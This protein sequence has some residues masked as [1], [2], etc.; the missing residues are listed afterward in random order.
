MSRLTKR[1][2]QQIIKRTPAELKGTSPGS[3]YIREVLGSFTP[4]EANWSYV[5]G[6]TAD[7]RLVVIRHGEIM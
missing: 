3:S 6:W 4:N 5:A 2:I 7:D 1:Q